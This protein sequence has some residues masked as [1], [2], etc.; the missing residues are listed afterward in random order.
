MNMYIS[1]FIYR[2]IDLY[3][4]VHTHIYIPLLIRGAG[5]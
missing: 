4:Y 3:I 1:I 2:S 5:A